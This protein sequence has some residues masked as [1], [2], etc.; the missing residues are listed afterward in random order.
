MEDQSKSKEQLIG[1]LHALRIRL[2][3]AEVLELELKRTR[4]KL[5]ALEQMVNS[6]P[7]G[8]T[9]S[10]LEGRILYSNPAEAQMHGYTVE[11]LTGQEVKI[12]APQGRW[13][14]LDPEQAKKIKRLT[15][16]AINLRKDGSTFEALLT[17]D[18]VKNKRGEA[19]AIITTSEELTA[20]KQA[21]AF[22]TAL[23]KISDKAAAASD[24]KTLCSDLH[25]IVGGL[26][27][28]RNFYLALYDQEADNL[29]FPYFVDEF[30]AA[31][32][33]QRLKKGLIKQVLETGQALFATQETY[34]QMLQQG[35]YEEMDTPFV[36]W[37]GVPLKKD[38]RIFGV[39][40]INSYTEEISFGQ[41][42][43]DLMAFAAQQMVNAMEKIVRA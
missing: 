4:E 29:T 8:V 14:P 16:E 12:F 27:Y 10:D 31:P 5:A 21:Q 35:G 36:N 28:A 24:L 39:M 7:M 33:P 42:E 41:T 6:L 11:E 34:S 23:Y 2:T 13:S 30:S 43:K 1:E 32:G 26:I 40:V 15:R 22:M 37:L 9:I 17:S 20:R 25:N 3:E 19:L 18:V 38:G